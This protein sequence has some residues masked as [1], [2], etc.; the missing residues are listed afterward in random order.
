MRISGYIMLRERGLV[1]QYI[2][3]DIILEMISWWA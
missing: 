3:N 2:E 1:L